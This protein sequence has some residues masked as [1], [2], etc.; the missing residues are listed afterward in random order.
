MNNKKITKEDLVKIL[1]ESLFHLAY[2]DIERILPPNP[3]LAVFILGA[4]FID[5][6][7]SFRFGVTKEMIKDGKIGERF[8]NFVKEYLPKYNADDLWDSLRCGLVHLYTA[9]GKYAFANKKRHFHH[10]KDNRGRT[11]INDED[12]CE[13][14]KD[15]YEK[16]KDDIL[17]N[18]EVY[19]NATKRLNSMGIMRIGS[20]EI[21]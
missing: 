1:D 14:L 5:A 12:F 8:K 4:C 11:I 21:K 15:V 19:L 3:N 13:E 17:N 10:R 20:V 2:G 9:Y 7:A 16:L 6:M 18:K